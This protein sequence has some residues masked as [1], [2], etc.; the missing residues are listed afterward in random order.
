MPH[1]APPTPDALNGKSS[2]IVV[3][4]HTDPGLVLGDIVHP[5]R[6]DPAQIRNQEDQH[7]LRPT[8]PVPSSSAGGLP[9]RV[10][11]C[12]ARSKCSEAS[13]GSCDWLAREPTRAVLVPLTYPPPAQRGLG[14]GRSKS[15]RK[16]Y[17]RVML[18]GARMADAALRGPY[19]RLAQLPYAAAN[20]PARHH[21]R[22]P[23]PQRQAPAA[24]PALW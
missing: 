24:A 1:A 23:T 9:G 12:T 22:P 11:W 5:I 16:L 8:L 7:L 4:P 14:S 21:A 17:S 18:D 6:T 15:S 13:L 20:R 10:A 19:G 2:R 3:R